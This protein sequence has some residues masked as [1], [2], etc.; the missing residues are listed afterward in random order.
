[1]ILLTPVIIWNCII[2]APVL[3]G[4]ALKIYFAFCLIILLGTYVALVQR[5]YSINPGTIL[6]NN[7]INLARISFCIS[8]SY[9]FAGLNKKGLLQGFKIL[10]QLAPWL[11]LMVIIYYL[12]NSHVSGRHSN[13]LV[14][15]DIKHG[16]FSA[17]MVAFSLFAFYNVYNEKNW[18]K[19]LPNII[20]ILLMGYLIFQMGSKN[21]LLG[22]ALVVIFSSYYFFIKGRPLRFA[23]IVILLTGIF[24]FI[25]NKAVNTPTM[26]RLLAAETTQGI[27][28]NTLT[29]KRYG[30]W[31]AGVKAF[32]SPQSVIGYGSSSL[33]SR[34][35]TGISPDAPE[36]NVLHNTPLEF[37][38][39]FGIPG[40]LLYSFLVFTVVK[41]FLFFWR[42]VKKNQLSPI[43]LLPF[44]CFFSIAVSGMFLSWQ[45]ESYWW[46]QT[47]LIFAIIKL[48]I[49][50]EKAHKQ[51]LNITN[52]RLV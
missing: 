45:W 33:A 43:L 16:E 37:A 23:A 7:L 4:Q 19:K 30:L 21:G 35:I 47:A 29:T 40:L 34:W 12:R 38:I 42:L 50:P 28:I 39:Q 9:F 32:F 15:G 26:Q 41:Y 31:V 3:Y 44:L 36:D 17:V 6:Q 1:M 10:L 27:N 51:R 20:S 46:Y 2:K 13:Y 52:A 11:L 18:V 22:L 48:F 14:V 49:A 5:F 24:Y 25:I 8:L